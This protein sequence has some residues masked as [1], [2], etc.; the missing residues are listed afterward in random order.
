MVEKLL[1]RSLGARLAP[2]L[3][4]SKYLEN[5]ARECNTLLLPG[6]TQ[7]RSLETFHIPLHFR[8]TNLPGVL[9]SPTEGAKA[10]D[11]WDTLFR[12]PRLVLIGEAGAGKSTS[13]KYASAALA[14]QRMPQA[15]VR[16]LTFLHLG[17]AFDQLLPVYAN[18]NQLSPRHADLA[19]FLADV[20][21]KYGFS[22]AGDTLRNKLTQGGCILFLD[23]LDTLVSDERRAQLKTLLSA[24]PKTQVVIA[25]R[26]T[27]GMNHF[28]GF[29]CFEA[30]P[31]SEADI[32]T[33][34]QQRLGKDT[35]PAT[36]LLQA[37]ER[38]AGLGSVAGNP[39]L[40]A[41]LASASTRSV[42]L[43]LRLPSL[44]DECLR[45][46]LDGSASPSA[47]ALD[48]TT[49]DQIL[50]ELGLNLQKQHKERL[51]AAEL[52]PV[53][54]RILEQIGCA[55]K[56]QSAL[57]WLTG[58]RLLTQPNGGSYAF[59]RRVFQDYMAA[60]VIVTR[61]RLE[62]VLSQYV[63]D[64]WWH[65]TI[66]LVAALHGNT[67]HIIER[68][69]ESGH[70]REAALLLATHC[71]IEA[72]NSAPDL[73]QSLRDRLFPIFQSDMS[74]NWRDSATCIA[75]LDG[76]RVHDYFPKAL[77]EGSVT[78]R[79]RAAMI[80][81]RVG[82]PDW[83][84]IPLLGALDR[85]APPEV[86]GQAAWALG[87]L[88]DK[89]AVQQL[90]T[91]LK[92]EPML[93]TQ[94]AMAL[95]V[96]GEPAVPNL[97]A[98][99]NSEDPQVRKMAVMSL[100]KM[101][102]QS[103]RPLLSIVQDEKQPD[104]AV[105]GAAEALGLLGDAE[106]TPRLVSLLRGRGGKLADTAAR[107]LAA[108]G[109]P[110]VPALITALPAHSAEL[111][112]RQCIVNAL[113][114]IGR[115]ALPALIQALNSNSTAV[116]GAAED[117]LTRIGAPAIDAL[118]EALHS[119]ELNLRRRIAEILERIGD[120]RLTQPLVSMLSD[121]DQD[122]GVRARVLKILGQVGR[123]QAVA[124]LVQAMR[125]DPDEFVRR[126]AI[127]ALMDLKSEQAVMPL[128]E[129]LQDESLRE[130]AVAALGAIGE[131][132]VEPLIEAVNSG[133]NS[134]LQE[135]CISALTSIGE[136]G[137]VGEPTLSALAHI[138]AHLFMEKPTLDSL[139][140]LLENIRWWK[141]GEEL[142]QA[143]TSTQALLQARS[144]NDIAD[145]PQQLAWVQS[146]EAPLRPPITE[147]LVDLNHVAQNMRVYLSEAGR[148]GQRDAMLSAIDALNG[149][150]RTITTALLDFEKQ[151]FADIV[152]KWRGLTEEAIKNLRGRAQLQIALLRDDLPIDATSLAGDIFFG[153]TNVGDSA[154]RNLSVTLKRGGRDGFEI[155][156]FPTQHLEPLGTGMHR[157]VK[158]C[159]KPLSDVKESTFAFEV[160]YDDD[161]G[162]GR[163]YPISGRVR[164]FQVGKEYHP[165]PASPYNWG[166]PV[167]TQ[168]MFYG[169]QEVFDWIYENIS[170]PGQDNFL[171]LHG[172]R[173]MGKTSVLYQLRARPPTPQLICVFFSLELACTDSIGD[174]FYDMATEITSELTK[175]GFAA[176]EP[177]EDNFMHNGQRAFLRFYDSVRDLLGERRLLIMVD[178]IDILIAKVEAGVLSGD[179]LNF[180]RGLMQHSNKIAFLFTG[181]YKVR[182][183]LKD[184]KS[185]LFNIAR[186][187]RISYLT[188]PEAE[189]L[190]VEPV[191]GYLIYDDMVVRRIVEVSACHPYFI[192]YICDSLVKLAQ[193]MRKN[194]VT[195]Q[196]VDVV[197]QDIIQDN[198]GV[199]QN[200]VYAPLSGTEQ[201]V[202]AGLASVTDENRVYVLPDIIAQ[203]LEE[204]KLNVP[205]RDLLDS[206]RALCER[207]LVVEQRSGQSLT[208]GFKMGLIRMWLRQNEV[209]LRLSQ[210]MRV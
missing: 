180:I 60:R 155:I 118:L 77:R 34:V 27:R 183:T 136:R 131:P 50:Q 9:T 106:A 18:L 181:A 161:E 109:A 74:A 144:L 25:S 116:R 26:T 160:T 121:K 112:L 93:A 28:P 210:E 171:I 4:I 68:I 83:A 124:P 114:S 197:L 24:Y 169:R 166:P 96:I 91:M 140:P 35:P 87:Q 156:G 209:L 195:L 61:E 173:R 189:A 12:S 206:L 79:Q 42:T 158:F 129:V 67:A 146:L 1:L 203:K 43:P 99:L 200:S 159:I 196:D 132:A 145:C 22:R 76:Q 167:K 175:L 190:I 45:E 185:I 202:L 164:F 94:A 113:V 78:E 58:S 81:G 38:S 23:D 110:A 193:K 97:I 82:R 117:A 111:E 168:Q 192:Q 21:D 36:A 55:G 199:L 37:L 52:Q 208:Y 119:G 204:Y 46:L 108:L 5:L 187:Y 151:P 48:R 105:K 44:Y 122:P 57:T 174:L 184:N 98:V 8:E 59:V 141:H 150:E 148:A 29:L 49:Q 6:E 154:A 162:D 102:N 186:P 170:S 120:E 54:S 10:L 134:G 14:L 85:R 53:I 51:D 69:L 107:A 17:Q 100:G 149:I 177:S 71:A 13:L 40:L 11:L 123:A 47:A 92:E 72:P 194:F 95:S 63:D 133:K 153:L 157:D 66:V 172:E 3:Y 128:I 84:T 143:F 32:I 73:K 75:A 64:P 115:P 191:S 62:Q 39:F 179:A 30:L 104:N 33:F 176:P 70:D 41:I 125:Q 56:E 103:L 20:V 89:H 88:H 201:K 139:V 207:D 127:R 165:I 31:F 138:Y 65:T 101:G 142:Y 90:M 163:F 15:Y 126:E 135:A 80:I 2:N 19:A 182:E 205:R 16:R 152:E 178:E 130:N 188:Q 147:A 198:A 86:R 137:R 7:T